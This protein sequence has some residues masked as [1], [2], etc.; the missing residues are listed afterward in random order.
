[1]VGKGKGANKMKIQADVMKL[2]GV[3]TDC[4]TYI[5]RNQLR[6]EVRHDDPDDRLYMDFDVWERNNEAGLLINKIDECLKDI[7]I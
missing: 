1:M 2:K 5:L 4:R 7:E 6:M 3:L